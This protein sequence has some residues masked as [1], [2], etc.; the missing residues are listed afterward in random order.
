MGGSTS[1]SARDPSGNATRRTLVSPAGRGATEALAL[2][3]A[4]GASPET[5]LSREYVHVL[6][7]VVAERAW[8]G[9]SRTTTYNH[10]ERTSGPNPDSTFTKGRW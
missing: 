7:P 6:G 3:C 8:T 1:R 10:R 4:P 9:G 2:A 5:T